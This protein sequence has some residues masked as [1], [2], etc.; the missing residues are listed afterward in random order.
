MVMGS[1]YLGV[2]LIDLTPELRAHFGA[3]E[4]AGAIVGNVEPGS[5]AEEAGLRVGDVV[6]T[7]DGVDVGN[8]WDLVQAVRPR[9][10]GQMLA[11]EVI[12][13]KRKK[14]L[15]AKVAVRNLEPVW[16]RELDMDVAMD[17]FIRD[18]FDAFRTARS[19]F[20]DPFN[21]QWTIETEDARVEEFRG[22]MKALEER[23]VELEQATG[24]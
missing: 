16:V 15:E 11:L 8:T 24:E 13:D 1:G 14:R 17:P 9:M 21:E 3:P 2:T 20:S 19:T 18:A 10:E 6:V 12:R 22:R 7:A 23:I 5:P 4:D